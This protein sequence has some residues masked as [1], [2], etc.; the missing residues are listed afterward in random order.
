[1]LTAHYDHI[2]PGSNY[3]NEIL[4][5]KKNKIH[6]GAD[7]NASGVVLIIELFKLITANINID[8]LSTIPALVLFSG[9]EEG[10]FG[11]KYWADNNTE[12][13][14]IDFVLNFDMIGKMDTNTNILTIRHNCNDTLFST[15]FPNYKNK[16]NN[17]CINLK[18][19]EDEKLINNS[20]AGVFVVKN[21]PAYTISTGIHEDYHKISDTA[22]KINYNG[23]YRI[24]MFFYNIIR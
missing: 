20:D 1:M 21:I 7:D 8:T 15:I 19:R 10:L 23:M 22:E 14:N 11:S 5:H 16:F 17:N 2:R 3:S 18:F 4:E 24:L 12:F 6:H 9:H 13:L